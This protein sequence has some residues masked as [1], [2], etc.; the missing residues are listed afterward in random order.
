LRFLL[1]VALA[2]TM[3]MS[4][5]A[6]AAAYHWWGPSPS[7]S[8]FPSP[9]PS[10]T[11]APTD[12]VRAVEQEVERLI[13]QE[14]T[15]RGLPA[16]TVDSRLV[17][18]SRAHSQDMADYN[19]LAH[20]TPDGRSWIAY[21]NDRGIDYRW[22]GEI[23]AYNHASDAE[24]AR[25]VVNQWMGSSGHRNI[26]LNSNPTHVGAG[27]AKAANGRQYHTVQFIRP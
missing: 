20:S 19:Y 1:S 6:P 10:P 15:S 12:R 13:N 3:L 23:I 27:Y 11:P 22:A 16:L 7:P 26:I 18:S 8:P 14:R 9:S 21:L 25:Y 17:A 5:A 24:T 4:V 2:V